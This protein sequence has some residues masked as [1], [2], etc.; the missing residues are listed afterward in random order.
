MRFPVPQY[1]DVEDKMFGQLT[2]KQMAYLCGGGAFVFIMYSI[3]GFFFAVLF[4]GPFAL[5]A[6]ALAFMKINERPFYL[7]V[8]ALFFYLLSSRLY[9]WKKSDRKQRVE[10]SASEDPQSALQQAAPKLSQSRLKELAWTLD[11]KE[12]MYANEGQW[13]TH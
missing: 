1:I 4:G 11:T 5:L 10:K 6:L 13:R 8:Y 2:A 12:S 9:L 3:G 7:I